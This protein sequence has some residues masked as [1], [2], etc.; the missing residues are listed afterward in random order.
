MP[1]SQPPPIACT[2]IRRATRERNGPAS[3]T[4]GTISFKIHHTHLTREHT[5]A[6]RSRTTY[7][8]STPWSEQWQWQY[9]MTTKV[10]C[11]Y[12][13][14][15]STEIGISNSSH[16]LLYKTQFRLGR[17]LFRSNFLLHS[18][19]ILIV[20]F[21]SYA[22]HHEVRVSPSSTRPSQP[23]DPA[24]HLNPARRF[25]LSAFHGTLLDLQ[26]ANTEGRAIKVT[27]DLVC[28][29]VC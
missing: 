3:A 17:H 26:D 19:I 2:A 11:C 28:M 5:L 22:I 29:Y 18:H 4:T 1:S 6:P 14:D 16:S 10:G 7:T 8:Y 21:P 27:S 25:D 20:I 13:A 15:R 12:V 24:C 23:T 9:P